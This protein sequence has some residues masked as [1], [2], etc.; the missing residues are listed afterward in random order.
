MIL[1]STIDICCSTSPFFDSVDFKVSIGL[2]YGM[3]L[4]IQIECKRDNDHGKTQ[5][6]RPWRL[7]EISQ[8]LIL[9]EDKGAFSEGKKKR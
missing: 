4:K 3:D 1:L 2:G 8:Q 6:G 5:G 7:Q 9:E